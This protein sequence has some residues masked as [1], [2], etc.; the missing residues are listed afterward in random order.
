MRFTY[1]SEVQDLILATLTLNASETFTAEEIAA[2][3]RERGHGIDDKDLF[4]K[5]NTFTASLAETT[6]VT[7]S[8]KGYKISQAGCALMM[9][10]GIAPP[11]ISCLTQHPER[12]ALNL[13]A[14]TLAV[15]VKALGGFEE[16]S[17]WD[18]RGAIHGMIFG[19][20][21][22]G[23]TTVIEGLIQATWSTD[24]IR[25]WVTDYNGR[26]YA[27]RMHPNSRLAENDAAIISM[28]DDVLAVINDREDILRNSGQT[29]WTG[30]TKRMPLG[31]LIIAD[32]SAVLRIEGANDRLAVIMRMARKVGISVIV[33]TS[34]LSIVDFRYNSPARDIAVSGNVLILRNSDRVIADTLLDAKHVYIPRKLENGDHTA[35]IGY[36][37]E[38]EILRA[39]MIA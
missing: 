14:G 10:K 39:F 12:D 18:S 37:R 20:S 25:S 17:L 15:G 33:E 38:R 13:A 9:E 35:G 30:P 24:M 22:S 11:T 36:N 32:I 4:R 7:S 1:H 5:V 28:L 27:N 21:G 6:L 26:L 34:T 23:K 29:N 31:L 3:I 8:D 2:D 19:S 16:W